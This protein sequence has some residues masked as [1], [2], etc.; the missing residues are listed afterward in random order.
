[1]NRSIPVVRRLSSLSPPPRDSQTLTLPSGRVLGYAEYGVP[2]GFPLFY[3]HGYP[4]C[5][6]EGSAADALAKQKNL[7]LICIDRPGFGLSTFQPGRRFADWPADV[8]AFADHAHLERFSVLG[9]SGGGP[10]AIACARFLPPERLTSVGVMAGGPPWIAG[11]QHMMRS[12]RFLRMMARWWPS[13]VGAVVGLLMRGV[14]WALSTSGGM[15]WLRNFLR[16]ADR[17]PEPQD[18]KTAEEK[19]AEVMRM[20]S[21]PFAQGTKGFVQETVLLSADDW[22]FKF[23]D[24]TYPVQLWHGTKDINSPIV[25]IKYMTERMPNCTLKELN[26]GHFGIMAYLGHIFDELVPEQVRDGR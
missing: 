23:E 16:E 17:K 12:A 11:H 6:L 10:Y 4:S 14:V 19:R 22:G 1:M 26:M 20:L 2:T 21:E 15:N 9:G 18:K 24:V 3:F 13:L 7:R 8:Q 5:R 25:M